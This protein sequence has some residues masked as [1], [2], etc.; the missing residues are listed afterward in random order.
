[1]TGPVRNML[2]RLG[3]E[4][5]AARERE[6]I[7]RSIKEQ[8]AADRR[9][10]RSPSK[11]AAANNPGAN[12]LIS[13]RAM[14]LPLMHQDGAG[15]GGMPRSS[16]SEPASKEAPTQS[17]QVGS[18]GVLQGDRART[19]KQAALRSEPTVAEL[20]AKGQ[21]RPI[22]SVPSQDAPVLGASI[23]E[24]VGASLEGKA[25]A[26]IEAPSKS[27]QAQNKVV[28]PAPVSVQPP[29]PDMKQQDASSAIKGIGQVSGEKQQLASTSQN[30]PASSDPI[31]ASKI[32]ISQTASERSQALHSVGAPSGQ[33]PSGNALRKPSGTNTSLSSNVLSPIH[34]Q[35]VARA[36][37]EPPAPVHRTDL[38]GLADSPAS[39]IIT[40]GTSLTST[41]MPGEETESVGI[42]SSSL[43]NE[44]AVGQTK[45][46]AA[47]PG[48]SPA[49]TP[50]SSAAKASAPNNP[51]FETGI[52]P[53]VAEKPHQPSRP[54]VDNVPKPE[55]A[56]P[57]TKPT[58]DNSGSAV[59][60]P[61]TAAPAPSAPGQSQRPA[62]AQTNAK[63][64]QTLAPSRPAQAP[65]A[66]SVQPT[67]PQTGSAKQPA[68]T[69]VTS[70]PAAAPEEAP[71]RAPA[72]APTPRP[73]PARPIPRA[74]TSTGKLDG[75]K[76]VTEAKAP[77]RPERASVAPKPATAELDPASTP[78]ERSGEGSDAKP[79][80]EKAEIRVG[81]P[82]S[83]VA[84]K[85]MEPIR[86]EGKKPPKKPKPRGKTRDGGPEP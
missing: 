61:A 58:R 85:M 71:A 62:A 77:A 56:A 45:N 12:P 63:L 66:P 49:P 29:T 39:I 73:E 11:S 3:A 19:T 41:S 70:A 16:S 46:T 47:G 22:R 5:E 52:K 57:G 78:G 76:A 67:A 8:I 20:I 86:I 75:A 59:S 6:A 82:L 33:E 48:K 42:K 25:S 35:E 36:V 14:E 54:A 51:R 15:V 17:P 2:E 37:H 40:S 13:G 84:P 60:K 31:S 34:G 83:P 24:S 50:A 81:Y 23:T 18:T 21:G 10:P 43:P 30:L 44:P 32:I 65:A 1:V 26:N 7:K 38:G 55:N 53:V 64:G 27:S 4:S 72:Q 68:T 79:A 28:S 9:S 74:E 69:K 80:K